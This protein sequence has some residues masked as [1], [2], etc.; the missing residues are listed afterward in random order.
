MDAMLGLTWDRKFEPH[1]WEKH[2]A[3]ANANTNMEAIWSIV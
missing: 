3:E 1:T 2:I